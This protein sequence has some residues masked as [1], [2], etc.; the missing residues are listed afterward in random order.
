MHRIDC[1][2]WTPLADDA[3]GVQT[4]GKSRPGAGLPTR[5]QSASGN[6]EASFTPRRAVY[7]ATSRPAEPLLWCRR[8]QVSDGIHSCTL[9]LASQCGQDGQLA[10]SQGTVLRVDEVIANAVMGH[11][12]DR[13][14][15]MQ[16][17]AR[18]H[19]QGS[20]SF[21]S[22]HPHAPFRVII[23]L[24]AEAVSHSNVIGSPRPLSC[25]S[26][27]ATG[28]S[29][30]AT[31]QELTLRP[32]PSLMLPSRLPEASSQPHLDVTLRIAYAP[33]GLNATQ[34]QLRSGAPAEE[35]STPEQRG[36]PR[37]VPTTATA[38]TG[39]AINAARVQQ[40]TH[41][42]GAHGNSEWPWG[43]VATDSIR[44]PSPP[45]APNQP[46]QG[47]PAALQWAIVPA[48]VTP[49]L[50][51][52]G[53][54]AAAGRSPLV[55]PIVPIRS[56]GPASGRWSIKGRCTAKAQMRRQESQMHDTSVHSQQQGRHL[57]SG[58]MVLSSHAPTYLVV[59]MQ[60]E[61]CQGRG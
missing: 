49:P 45:P 5:A 2:P 58:P 4:C 50:Q 23:V 10:L 12:Y 47:P 1:R 39:T 35:F 59:R 16:A 33:G 32:M 18:K 31:Q 38:A 25:T 20:P 36:T 6:T 54:G 61:Q 27:D 8:L 26:P 43:P 56:L 53:L 14:L 34:E 40:A 7:I 11:R 22:P 28:T 9:V 41:D 29:G 37:L 55:G 30:S 48:P 46:G 44:G 57:T 3:H 15:M 52:Q 17:L 60:V 24:E 42:L 13:L 19:C 51:R 21:K